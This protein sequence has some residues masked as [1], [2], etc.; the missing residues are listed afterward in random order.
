MDKVKK[1]GPMAKGTLGISRMTFTMERDS[2]RGRIR[3]GMKGTLKRENF[4]ARA[5]TLGLI[6]QST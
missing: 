6:K 1:L 3:G 2:T 5:P 4:P